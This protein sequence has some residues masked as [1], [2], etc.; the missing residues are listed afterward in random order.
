MLTK[1]NPNIDRIKA[2]ISCALVGRPPKS[3]QAAAVASRS[4]A[5]PV[6]VVAMAEFRVV[7]TTTDTLATPT[8]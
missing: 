2:K 4:L 7:H 1:R 3:S 8:P 5:L 6:T